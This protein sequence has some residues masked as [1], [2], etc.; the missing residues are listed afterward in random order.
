MDKRELT[1]LFLEQI[2]ADV[3]DASIRSFMSVWW[4]TPRSPIGLRLSTDGNRFLSE[5]LKLDK[6]SF[7]IKEDTVKSLRLFL[8][9]NKYL[10]S[11]YYLKGNNTI[12]FYGEQDAIMMGLMGGDIAQYLTNFSR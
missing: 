2:G 1:K 12:I 8:Q 11:P 4:F 9:M 5:V 10:S 7:T 3:S 6:Y